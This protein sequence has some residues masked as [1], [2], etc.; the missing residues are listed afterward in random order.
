MSRKALPLSGRKGRRRGAEVAH[1]ARPV[2]ATPVGVVGYGNWGRNIV[3]DLIALGAAVTVVARAETRRRAALDAGAARVVG[4]VDAL[5]DDLDGLVVATPTVT[6]AEVTEQLIPYGV[7]IYVEKPLTCD[8]AEA[9]HLAELAPDRLFVMHKWRYHPGI[10]LLGEIARSGELGPVVGLRTVRLGWGNPH[11]DVDGVWI[12]AP[13]DLSIALEVLGEIPEPRSAVAEIVGGKWAGI[14]GLLGDEPWFALEASTAHPVRR[15]EIRLVCRDGVA[16][17][18]DP[19]ADH[20]LVTRGEP[21]EGTREE[22]RR[23]ITTEFP[24]V[25]E[26]RA[27]LEHLGGGP[28]PKSS[29]EEAVADVAA[30]ERLRELASLEPVT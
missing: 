15:R 23:Q 25:R 29:A 1:Y 6:H 16:L 8:A 3:R 11:P 13:H 27:F 9:R 28:P 17:V 14:V 21:N 20:I 10:E 5:P 24:L 4:A 7:P 30:I 18:H 12:L 26:L 19:Y 2:A 22:E